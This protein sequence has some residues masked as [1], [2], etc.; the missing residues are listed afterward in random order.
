MSTDTCL[1]RARERATKHRPRLQRGSVGEAVLELQS[2]LHDYEFYQDTLHHY[3]D[4]AVEK[5]VVDFQ[6]CFLLKGDGIVG[7]VTWQALYYAA[8]VTMPLLERGKAGYAVISVQ[9]SLQLTGDYQGPVDGLFGPQTEHAVQD[10]QSGYGL[11][12][13]GKVSSQTWLALSSFL[14][15]AYC[16]S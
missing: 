16:P 9:R 13:N 11:I 4:A 10:F 3:F 7:S 8:P 15:Y 2:L 6:R 5:A 14:T 12:A 1:D